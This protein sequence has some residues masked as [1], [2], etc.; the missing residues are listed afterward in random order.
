[1][2]YTPYI[3]WTKSDFNRHLKGL[4]NKFDLG[5]PIKALIEVA[6]LDERWDPI[7]DY[8]GCTLVQ[9]AYHPCLSCFLHDY[10]WN[11]GQGGKNAD[12]LFQWLMLKEGLTP[13]KV[14]RRYLAVRIYWLVYSKW[15]YF[16]QRNLEPY[17]P[18]FEAVLKYINKEK[19]KT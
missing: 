2:K 7:T 5:Q 3:N 14:K 18:E 8:D 10:L 13:G 9:D 6:L 19:I 1:M 4:A 17:S 11:T 16:G 15:K 12:A